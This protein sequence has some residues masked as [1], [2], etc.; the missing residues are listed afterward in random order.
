MLRLLTVIAACGV[1]AIPLAAQT[2]VTPDTYQP[3][4]TASD[5]ANVQI[6]QAAL[7]PLAEP[8]SEILAIEALLHTGAP[9]FSPR[10]QLVVRPGSPEWRGASGSGGIAVPAPSAMVL[11]GL[12]GLVASRR[13]AR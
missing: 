11:L 8:G 1:P 7:G 2:T 13:R 12:A 3:A 6:E 5:L 4:P 10:A 9:E